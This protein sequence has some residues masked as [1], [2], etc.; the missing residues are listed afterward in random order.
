MRLFADCTSFCTLVGIPKAFFALVLHCSRLLLFSLWHFSKSY[1][2]IIALLARNSRK[3]FIISGFLFDVSCFSSVGC[4]RLSRRC[5]CV[6]AFSLICQHTK[7]CI[8]WEFCVLFFFRFFYLLV[9]LIFRFRWNVGWRMRMI[10]R[11]RFIV[12][13]RW[14]EVFEWA[15]SNF[16]GPRILS[17]LITVVA[18]I[19]WKWLPKTFELRL[20]LSFYFIYF[21]FIS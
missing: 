3:K 8:V 7:N 5:M 11:K 16:I 15:L 14:V 19:W 20:H 17:T 12:L 10:R 18:L 4:V 13:R 2:F 1:K 21:L 6:H 9:F